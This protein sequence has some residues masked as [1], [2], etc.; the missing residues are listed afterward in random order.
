MQRKMAGGCE[1]RLAGWETGCQDVGDEP[2]GDLHRQIGHIIG[3]GNLY[4]VECHEI[5]AGDER[6]EATA[7]FLVKEPANLRRAGARR[8]SRV[9]HIHV[10]GDVEVGTGG[11][12]CGDFFRAAL[13]KLSGGNDGVAVA[14]RVFLGSAP[15]AADADRR[16][17][18]NV[19]QFVATAYRAAV[20]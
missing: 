4:D 14:D 20:S 8:L 9:E 17:T 5:G 2:G 10:E 11:N 16:D 18:P 19:C 15:H 12:A 3:R 1:L 6:G 7:G 13:A